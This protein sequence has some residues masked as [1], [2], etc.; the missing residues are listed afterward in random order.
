MSK[1]KVKKEQLTC[2]CCKGEIYDSNLSRTLGR[3]V[4]LWGTMKI[5]ERV[6]LK[7]GRF[8]WACD[9]CLNSGKALIGKPESQ[10]YCDFDP[11]L[12]Y[13]DMEKVCEKCDQ[14]YLF[15]KEE[16]KYWYET[17]QFWVQSKP[18]HCSKCR[19][20]IREERE[21]NNELAA[22]LKEKEKL[23]VQDMERLSKIYDDIKKPDKSKYYK[24][25]VEKS[26]HKIA[27]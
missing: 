6:D 18:K 3:K 5:L 19:H 7:K 11:Y 17:L 27:S 9:E 25:L 8:Q 1:A 2:S 12:V 4:W 14:D 15:R 20:E 10:L 23:T 13:I 26:K 21:L 16:Q 22:L 24:N